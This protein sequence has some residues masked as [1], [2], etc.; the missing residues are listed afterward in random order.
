MLSVLFP[1]FQ[2]IVV[3]VARVCCNPASQKSVPTGEKVATL[4]VHSS[5]TGALENS[6]VHRWSAHSPA[7]FEMLS[8]SVLVHM[9]WADV[10]DVMHVRDFL[11]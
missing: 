5:I 8:R 11:L 2:A 7:L 3:C 1:P 10:N 6:V 9:A 4:K